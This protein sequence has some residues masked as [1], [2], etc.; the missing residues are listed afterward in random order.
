MSQPRQILH[1]ISS[2]DSSDESRQLQQLVVRQSADGCKV[3]IVAFTAAS[4]YRAHLEQ[5]GATCRVLEMR[6]QYDP[7]ATYRLATEL[8]QQPHD[9]LHIWGLTP[10]RYAKFVRPRS[11]GVPCLTT[12]SHLPAEKLN[13]FADWLVV[14][15]PQKLGTAKTTVIPPGVAAPSS[16]PLSRA[17][18]LK[19]LS[20]PAEA[21]IIGMAGP[22]T[23]SRGLEEAIWCFELVRTLDERARLLIFGAGPDR[24]RLERFS[25]L[26]SEPSAIRF[27]GQQDD[28]E[29]WLPHLEVFWQLSAEQSAVPPLAALEAMASRVPVVATDL[30]VHRQIIE[31]RR[32]GFLFPVA[33]RAICARHTMQ[34][35]QDKDMASSIVASAADRVLGCFSM[36]A[37]QSAYSQ[38]YDQ[39]LNS[40]ESL[41]SNL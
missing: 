32:T 4:Q 2:L 11:A 26:A 36:E 19:L 15:S 10:L 31:A 33:S 22:L 30:A 5:A 23:R 29:P 16:G 6:W 41:T 1:L 37:F 38:L 27:L 39:L 35:L 20:L 18:F 34:L 12:L 13:S 40:T 28:L 14:P 21:R 9:L 17:E 25:R 7:I 24:H 8:R 3:R